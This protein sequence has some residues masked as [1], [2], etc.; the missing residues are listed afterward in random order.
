LSSGAASKDG[1]LHYRQRLHGGFQ[2]R[3]PVSSPRRANRAVR[4]GAGAFSD[5][6]GNAA[7][8]G[9]SSGIRRHL[10]HVASQFTA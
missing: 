4:F 3:D 10:R 6:R 2:R 9:C 8:A 7:K 1:P 5:S